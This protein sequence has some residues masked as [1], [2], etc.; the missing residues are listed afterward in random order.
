MWTVIRNNTYPLKLKQHF[1]GMLQT[2][3]V[4]FRKIVLWPYPQ[5]AGKVNWLE[6]ARAGC[7]GTAE[8]RV[9][10]L[11]R[12]LLSQLHKW[13]IFRELRWSS[14]CLSTSYNNV[15]LYVC[16]CCCCIFSRKERKDK[17]FYCFW[18]CD[19]HPT[20]VRKS[21]RNL[22]FLNLFDVPFHLLLKT[23]E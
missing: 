17:D 14:L 11:F 2:I 4:V 10:E 15:C 5:L 16:C 12:A 21:V 13:R 22:R 9:S 6:P 1:P 23:G 20:K 8:A 19:L 7:T 18:L 3:Q